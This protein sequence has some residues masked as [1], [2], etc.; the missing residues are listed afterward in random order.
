MTEKKLYGSV[1]IKAVQILDYLSQQLEPK[2]MS[3]ISKMTQITLPTTNKVLNTLEF[4]GF[5]KRHEESKTY[6]LGPRL[7]Q[8]ANAS[9]IQ[10]DFVR[11]TYPALKHLFE[12]VQA[13]INLAM[14][15]DFEMLYV[16]K[17]SYRDSSY[18]TLSRIGFT[19]GLHCSAMG[20]AV[21]ATLPEG[22]FQQY[23]DMAPYEEKTPYTITTSDQ[24]MEE[25][26]K[27][28]QQGFAVDDQEAELGVYCIAVAIN[29]QLTDEYY[30]FSVSIPFE[31]YSKEYHE[32]LLIELNKT[33]A[34][35]EYQL[36]D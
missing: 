34:I 1:L 18:Q 33:K 27:V 10:F 19:Q 3:D 12:R 11:E 24:L 20:K 32:E 22:V 15:Q 16:N 26:N 23:L 30:A 31:S 21:L 28:K 13:T 17:F 29:H 6:S 2:S 5:V 35:I 8:I 36:S 25:I 14:L 9:F 7:I 4:V